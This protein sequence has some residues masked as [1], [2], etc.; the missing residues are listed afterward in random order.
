[1]IYKKFIPEKW[2]EKK[3]SPNWDVNLNEGDV[4][5]RNS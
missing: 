4:V 2:N 1:M 3:K 5:N